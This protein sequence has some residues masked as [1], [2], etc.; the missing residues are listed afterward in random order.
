M[1]SKNDSV[2]WDRIVFLDGIFLTDMIFTNSYVDQDGIDNLEESGIP[3][4]TR[5]G[6]DF[7]ETFVFKPVHT[8]M[9]V[10]NPLFALRP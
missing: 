1:D 2:L 6:H 10:P 9:F 3:A 7:L 8:N 4:S 5:F